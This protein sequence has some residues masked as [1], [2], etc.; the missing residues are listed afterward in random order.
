MTAAL[1]LP[2]TRLRLMATVKVYPSVTLLYKEFVCWAGITDDRQWVRL[3]PI[4]IDNSRV[5]SSSKN[6][7]LLRWMCSAARCIRITVRKVGSHC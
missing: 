4:P 6:T 7:I 2:R 5:L 1:G 3:Y